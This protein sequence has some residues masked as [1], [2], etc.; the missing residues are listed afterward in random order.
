MTHRRQRLLIAALTVAISLLAPSA[1]QAQTS[2][3]SAPPPLQVTPTP[4]ELPTSPV[5][6][7]GYQLASDGLVFVQLYNKSSDLVQL[8]GWELTVASSTPL[9]DTISPI[10]LSGRLLPGK[11][12]VIG[13]QGSVASS[14]SEFTLPPLEAGAK[15]TAVSVSYIG[16]YAK[17]TIKSPLVSPQWLTLSKSSAG[18][19]TTTSKFTAALVNTPLY[20][21][22]MYVY[23]EESPLRVVEV[24]A[25]P[26]D[27]GP[28][29][30]DASCVSYVKLFNSSTRPVDASPYRLRLGYATQSAGITNAVTL[31]G[32]IAPG[33]YIAIQA[34]DDGKPLAITASG[35]HVWLEDQLGLKTYAE[36]AVSYADI[37]IEAHKGQAWAYDAGQGSR[38]WKWAAA[39][40]T[41]PS[42]FEVL[43]PPAVPS[44]T[45]TE[46][47]PQATPI[48]TQAIPGFV[49]C[50][51]GQER[52]PD[53]N[54]CRT[55]ATAA[56]AVLATCGANQERNP[57]TNRCRSIKAVTSAP[58]LVPCAAN[59]E[60]NPATNRCRSVALTDT[61]TTELK[62]CAA[63]QE[64]NPDTNRC[65]T[66]TSAAMPAAAF[67]PE[68]VADSP[69]T[70]TGWWAL[71]GVTMLGAGYGIWEW[72]REML[73]GI[74]KVRQALFSSK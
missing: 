5:I 17:E 62:P 6:V 73:G 71:G 3:V 43:P 49:P 21:G 51:V 22:G 65:R 66:A 69:T 26:R 25:N 61:A 8:D 30:Q 39:S 24:A 12:A 64:R 10:A 11:Y 74:Q 70:F 63:N 31:K 42:R 2:P 20:G 4:V 23:P 60:R 16:K 32:N 41:G 29:E 57:E 48:S 52:N 36:S 40:L 55:V 28:L 33:E 9:S 1:V 13:R 19:Y 50:K 68:A 35:G 54:R 59:Q 45:S 34:R 58:T 14:D 67:K 46:P 53:T 37:G 27:C 56:S 7:T 72:R 47:Q 38:V 44:A 15:V 18:N